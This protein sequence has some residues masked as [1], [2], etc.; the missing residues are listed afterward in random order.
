MNEEVWNEVFH[1]FIGID[2]LPEGEN[3]DENKNYMH[4]CEGR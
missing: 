4:C 2:T 1:T 3:E